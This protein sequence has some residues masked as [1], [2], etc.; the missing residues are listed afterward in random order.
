ML[1]FLE[2]YVENNVNEPF[3]FQC[4]TI[5]IGNFIISRENWEIAIF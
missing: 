3:V 4:F 5:L 2:N 1:L